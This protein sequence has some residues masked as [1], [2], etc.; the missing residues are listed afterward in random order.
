M[1]GAVAEG[2]GPDLF[3]E[4]E[5]ENEKVTILGNGVHGV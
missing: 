1:Q 5:G 3:A 2:V 4:F